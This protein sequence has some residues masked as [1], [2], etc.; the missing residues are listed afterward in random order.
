MIKKLKYL[1][2]Q[3]GFHKI[4]CQAIR[5]SLR[6]KFKSKNLTPVKNKRKAKTSANKNN[7]N[8]IQSSQKSSKKNTSLNKIIKNSKN[9]VKMIETDQ[10]VNSNSPKRTYNGM[11]LA[12]RKTLR[13]PDEDSSAEKDSK[14]P[15]KVVHLQSLIKRNNS[16]QLRNQEYLD[17]MK[18]IEEV[19][20]G[21]KINDLAIQS[22]CS[23]NSN[24]IINQKSIHKMQK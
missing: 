17:F 1:N 24:A 12:N 19:S 16:F 4:L 13:S 15:N 8:L 20:E 5:T 3:K 10:D 9:V 6:K 21:E 18:E 2:F 23:L 14:S 22:K 11:N 7:I